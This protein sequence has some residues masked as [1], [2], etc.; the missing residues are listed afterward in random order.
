MREEATSLP[1]AGPPPGRAW[2]ACGHL[3]RLPDSVF[4]RSTPSGMEKSI[5]IFS[6]KVWP[7]YHAD[8]L[9][10]ISSLFS[11]ADLG[12]NVFS[13]S[14]GTW[15]LMAGPLMRK[16]IMNPRGRKEQVPMRRRLLYLHLETPMWSSR[17]RASLTQ[18]RS[19]RLC[20]SLLISCRR[21]SRNYAKGC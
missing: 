11:A 4:V 18:G 14:M 1:G 5:Y 3:V 17:S 16:K 2:W 21:V 6:R 15:I 10:F 12:Q 19:L 9:C 8:F 7:S 13:R 20:L